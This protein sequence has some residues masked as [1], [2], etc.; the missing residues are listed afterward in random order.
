MTTQQK[1][2]LLLYGFL[3]SAVHFTFAALLTHSRL[4]LQR[5]EDMVGSGDTKP[6]WPPYPLADT[7]E[8]VAGILR[9]PF[10]W[11]W[12]PWMDNH[13]PSFFAVVLF[14][15]S[16]CLWGFALV[17]F[18]RFLFTRFRHQHEPRIA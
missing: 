8:R 7:L 1:R 13:L 18:A 12:T 10:D 3:L 17:V 16:S 2:R 11:F 15:A 5:S 14:A 9:L 6:Y 4:L